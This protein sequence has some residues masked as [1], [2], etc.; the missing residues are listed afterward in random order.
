MNDIENS[1][2][3]GRVGRPMTV[4]WPPH[5]RA[6][7]TAGRIY[8]TIAYAAVPALLAGLAF[9][10]W[11][12]MVVVG[13]AVLST[14]LLDSLFARL[15]HRPML[16]GHGGRA[17]TLLMGLLLG[18]SLPATVNWPIVVLAAL[19]VVV[20][21]KG[22]LGGLG[23]YLWHP[24]LLGRFVVQVFFYERVS[25]V[26]GPVL[27]S[28]H[29]YL[30]RLSDPAV[31]PACASWL[32]CLAGR[33]DAFLFPQ[34]LIAIRELVGGR[35][36]WVRQTILEVSRG[37][38]PGSPSGAVLFKLIWA[39]L[40]AL[41]DLLIGAVPGEIGAT[42]AIALLVGG[43]FLLY[44]GYVR[45]PMAVMFVASAAATAAV[46]PLRIG[47]LAGGV[48]QWHW[49]PGLQFYDA[50][51]VG[52]LYVAHHLLSGGLLLGV[53]FFAA[54][55]VSRPMTRRGQILFAIGCGAGTI[56]IRLYLYVPAAPY[57]FTTGATY[58]AIL[59][60]NTFTPLLD[61]IGQPRAFGR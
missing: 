12:A 58:L 17:H 1:A 4:D 33:S 60:M 21:G 36:D 15:A 30:G 6:S 18:L 13:T 48:P 9:F 39:K 49:L 27:D 54:D 8:A 34:P 47:P 11:P 10:G 25:P 19:A 40:P 20:I 2:M 35:A 7:E 32:S 53:F 29:L 31:V 22:L 5:W 50:M 61:R 26:E 56:L 45:W 16:A 41:T 37:A 28:K 38:D 46:A 14:L 55:F 51:P 57:L 52:P 23:H 3:R 43:L 24:V 42:S 59:A 44:Q